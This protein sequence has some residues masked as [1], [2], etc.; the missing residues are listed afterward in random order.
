[1]TRYSNTKGFSL[2]EVLVAT[3]LFSLWLPSSLYS[4]QVALSA[5]IQVQQRAELVEAMMQLNADIAEQWRDGTVT[6]DN[7][8]IDWQL[9]PIDGDRAVLQLTAEDYQLRFMLTR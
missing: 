6:A 8:D 3:A 5:H 7:N 2:M 9:S 4:L 1:M